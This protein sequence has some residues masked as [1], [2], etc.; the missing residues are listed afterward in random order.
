M[1][2]GFN[3]ETFLPFRFNRLAAEVSE[4]MS[5]L[6]AERFDLDIPKWRV[7]ATLSGRDGLTA[8]DIVAST[9]THKSTISRAVDEL[10]TRGL[11][12]RAVSAADKRSH[13]LRLTAEGR[14]LFRKLQPLVAE[15]QQTLLAGLTPEEAEA[16]LR[17]LAAMERVLK[18]G[19]SRAA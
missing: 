7:L 8:Q 14:K 18:L 4:R 6:Y 13:N 11:V 17:A 5:A 10:V 9:R 2:A 19:T 15:Y 1:I 16:L 12:E 3:L